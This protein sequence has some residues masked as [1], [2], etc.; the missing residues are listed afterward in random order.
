[1][2][3][4]V[5]RKR[6]TDWVFVTYFWF[7]RFTLSSPFPTRLLSVN[8]NYPDALGIPFKTGAIP[9]GIPSSEGGSHHTLCSGDTRDDSDPATSASGK[10][11][12]VGASY[13]DLQRR[14]PGIVPSRLNGVGK[15]NNPRDLSRSPDPSEGEEKT[16]AA[17]PEGD[18]RLLVKKRDASDGNASGVDSGGER[19]TPVVAKQRSGRLK[20]IFPDRGSASASAAGSAPASVSG[21]FSATGRRSHANSLNGEEHASRDGESPTPA[22]SMSGRRQGDSLMKKIFK[23][24]ADKDA[25]AAESGKDADEMASSLSRSGSEAAL[26]IAGVPG[27]GP[28]AWAVNPNA[29]PPR[30]PSAPTV[31]AAVPPVESGTAV[32]S[33]RLPG[34]F[35]PKYGGQGGFSAGGERKSE[36]DARGRK[37]EEPTKEGLLFAELKK[38]M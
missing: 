21:S 14:P 29:S 38:A 23:N 2:Y 33:M 7:Y 4:I 16:T 12:R 13:D 28:G 18:H 37:S 6:P 34:T 9:I 8:Q 25:R 36:L 31:P 26:S 5:Y 24:K 1:M 11:G 35:W 3:G 22:R 17:S 20:T 30:D 19:V 32:K 10:R 15:S 27:M